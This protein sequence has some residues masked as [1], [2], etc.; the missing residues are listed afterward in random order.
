MLP[1]SPRAFVSIDS[2]G[3]RFLV[4]FDTGSYAD[5]YAALLAVQRWNTDPDLPLEPKLVPALLRRVAQFGPT[6]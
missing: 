3:H 1:A 4:L 6:H 5:I 2:N